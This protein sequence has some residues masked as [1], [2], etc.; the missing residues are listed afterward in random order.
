M[1]SVTQS[2]QFTNIGAVNTAAFGLKGGKYAVITKSTGAGT[3]DLSVLSQDGV[4]FVKPTIAQI[5]A[6]TGFAVVDLPPGQYR[7]EVTGFTANF[8]SITS[9]PY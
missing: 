1:S 4:T 9:V 3:I 7:F 8:L 6:V 5:V 2:V